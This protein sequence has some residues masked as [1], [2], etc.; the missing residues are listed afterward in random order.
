[1]TK[2]NLVEMKFMLSSILNEKNSA[3]RQKV[4][5]DVMELLSMNEMHYTLA[6]KA[7]KAEIKGNKT[8]AD[9]WIEK[10]LNEIDEEE[11]E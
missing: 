3:L 7:W 10:I 6:E 8:K 11:Y 4:L 1:M 9:E 2:P 5:K